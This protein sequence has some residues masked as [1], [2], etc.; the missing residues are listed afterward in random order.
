[1]ITCRMNNVH[2]KLID[3]LLFT[4]NYN[5]FTG[6]LVIAINGHN[7][8]PKI[9][10]SIRADAWRLTRVIVIYVPPVL[11]VVIHCSSQSA[12]EI[13]ELGICN[14][15]Q[16][17]SNIAAKYVIMWRLSVTYVRAHY[18]HVCRFL[19]RVYTLSPLQ[20]VK[21]FVTT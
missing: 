18:R 5:R 4:S 20:K 12:C 21:C 7:D 1:M 6:C 9:F 3:R 2:Y 10:Y 11:W 15:P 17:P 16:G 13:S 19:R 14:S 8:H